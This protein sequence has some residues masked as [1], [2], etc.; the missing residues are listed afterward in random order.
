MSDTYADNAHAYLES[1]LGYPLPLPVGKK[2]PPPTGFIGRNGRIPTVD[3]IDAWCDRFPDAN[4]ALR[5]APGVIGIDVDAYVKNGVQKEGA[6]TLRTLEKQYGRLPATWISTSRDDGV[7]GIRIYRA[8][9]VSA[10]QAGPGIDI[11][12]HENRYIVAPPSVHPEGGV[13]RWIAPNGDPY[14]GVPQW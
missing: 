7:S 11:I 3:E 4:I 14:S 1:G 6:A 9:G 5:L 13:Y 12:H 2:A 8:D 10:G